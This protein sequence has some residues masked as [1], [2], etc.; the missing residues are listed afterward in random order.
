MRTIALCFVAQVACAV[1]AFAQETPPAAAPDT[2]EIDWSRA[3]IDALGLIRDLPQSSSAPR[4]PAPADS[5]TW[6]R[7]ENGNGSANV[8]QKQSWSSGIATNVGVDSVGVQSGWPKPGAAQAPSSGTA[9]ANAAIPGAGPIDQA[10]LDA[11]VD[12]DGDQRKFGARFEKSIPLNQQFSVTLQNG[13]GLSQPLATQTITGA[14]PPAHVFDSEQAAKLN[15][16]N[17]GTSVF[18]GSKQSSIDERRLNSFGAEQNFLGGLS[19]SGAV[20]ENA[21]GGHDRS[22][23]ARFKRSW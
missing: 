3:D 19:V 5:T 21:N 17:Y 10:T 14:P 20:S 18:A 12:P 11:R 1:P 16:L 4:A 2:P 13:Y 9:W 23:T 6:S 8:V 15:V 7:I 22:L